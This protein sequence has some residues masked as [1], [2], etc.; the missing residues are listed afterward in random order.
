MLVVS[1]HG[2]KRMDGGICVNEWLRREG[3]LVLK[4]EPDGSGSPD[5]RPHRL[6]A[7][8]RLGGGRLLLPTLPER[9]RTRAEGL[10]APDDYERVRAELKAKLE[11][12]GDDQGRP[13]GTVAHRPEDLYPE[14]N[15]VAPDLLV[16]FGDLYWRSIGQVGTGTV[17]VFENDTGPDDANHAHEGLYVLVAP[18]VPAGRG[19]EHDL[20]DVAPT[21][22]ALLGEPVP[23]RHGR[24]EH[25]CGRHGRG[26]LGQRGI[27]FVMYPCCR[28]LDPF[29]SACYPSRAVSFTLP[30]GRGLAK[31]RLWVVLL[32][33]LGLALAGFPAEAKAAPG[34][35]GYEGPS[36]AG[37]GSG[38]TA[39]KPESKV[40][41]NDGLWWA[42][43]WD[44]AS[45]DFH[46]FR[47]NQATQ[48][49]ADTGVALDDRGGKPC[50]RPVGRR[51]GQALRGLP[52]LHRVRGHRL[53][54]PSLPLQLRRGH[55][56][57]YEG[58]GIS[59]HDQQL[60]ARGARDR[61]GLDRQ[62]LG[63]LAAG[64]QDLGQPHPVHPGL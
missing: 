56:Y 16:Y 39:T 44:T 11:A 29:R 3:Y 60:Q 14:R 10:V 36:T 7:H 22:L 4:E 18:G 1:D 43:M 13:I 63:D 62:A 45:A 21:L 64:Q 49:W 26:R 61:Q 8:D 5:A 17:H 25:A 31:G 6:E 58:Y 12:L 33:M 38:T 19:P 46:I 9:R 30:G 27:G 20:R 41:W 54:E 2:A 37:A 40:W 32:A 53:G 35:I 42:S 55:G 28:F 47:L 23:R 52:R 59:S 50:R 51:R 48:T 24:P 34:D 15:G 57:V